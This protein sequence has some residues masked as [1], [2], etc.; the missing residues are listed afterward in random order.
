MG[1]LCK[2]CLLESTLVQYAACHLHP[3][4]TCLSTLRGRIDWGGG[5]V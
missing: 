1:D 5:V 4:S 2:D 3:V